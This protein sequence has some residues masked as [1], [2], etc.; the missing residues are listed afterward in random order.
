MTWMAWRQIRLPAQ[1]YIGAVALFLVVLA[2]TGPRMADQFD[3]DGLSRCALGQ[4]AT[5]DRTCGD[6]ERAFLGDFSVVGTLGGVLTL[7]PA[8]VGMFWGA[9]LLAREYE[10][11]IS[12]LAW[13]QSVTQ[14][15]WLAVR[16][17]VVGGL[18]LA[19]TAFYS[20]AFTWWS[21]PRDRLG[22][23]I[24][25]STFEQRGI[26]PIAYV[27][28]ALLTG[29]AVGAVIRRVV[30]ATAVTLLIVVVTMFGV[31]DYVRP[32]LFDPVELRF[33][34]YSFAA[35]EPADRIATSR[36]WLVSN[37]TI[38]RDGTVVSP[39]G[40][41]AEARA[42]E[43]CGLNLSDLQGR[44][45]KHLLDDCGK[46]LGL[47]DVAKVHPTSRFWALQAAEFALFLGLA[48]ALGL[49]SFSWIRRGNR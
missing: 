23:R 3:A 41:L 34:T 47:T 31:R 2:W 39:A 18:A 5:G 13:T 4:E 12:Q 28:F 32:H 25:P 6:L 15:R 27:A 29:V 43:I 17:A 16:L 48:A 38:D 9:P 37:K 10:S 8:V 20:L 24:S 19:V 36:G 26:V 42:A 49:F 7:L 11:R 14:R 46:R 45:A 33:P 30:P 40:E 22:S 44:Q 35:D 21:G 1:V